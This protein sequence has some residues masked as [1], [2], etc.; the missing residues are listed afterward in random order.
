[1][2]KRGSWSIWGT[3]DPHPGRDLQ[4]PSG[5]QQIPL[6]MK[7]SGCWVQPGGGGGLL[8]QSRLTLLWPHWLQPVR[9]LCPWDF[10]SKSTGVGCHFLLQELFPTQ[11]SNPGLLYCRQAPILQVDSLPTEP[12]GKPP[13]ACWSRGSN[14]GVW[15]QHIFSGRHSSC[16]PLAGYSCGRT[17]AWCCQIL[18]FSIDVEIWILYEV[19]QFGN[20]FQKKNIAKADLMS[21]V[22]S[23]WWLARVCGPNLEAL[24]VVSTPLGEGARRSDAATGQRAPPRP[25]RR[26]PCLLIPGS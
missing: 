21:S 17:W 15:K 22:R 20:W 4:V 23:V 9:L 13:S 19:F 10:P 8:A 6:V 14:S 3:E 16:S 25:G 11:G 12:S 26:W 1:M 2:R 7:G 18:H 24:Y 5:A